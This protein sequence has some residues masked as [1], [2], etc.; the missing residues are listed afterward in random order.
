MMFCVR[1]PVL[2]EK[3]CEMRPS[4]SVRNIH[5]T[6]IGV[7]ESSWYILSDCCMNHACI[8]LQTYKESIKETDTKALSKTKNRSTTQKKL[9][10][11]E[12]SSKS[13]YHA[14]SSRVLAAE[15]R[16]IAAMVHKMMRRMT[17]TMMSGLRDFSMEEARAFG[18]RAPC[19]TFVSIPVFTT[20]PRTYSVLRKQQPRSSTLLMFTAI[21]SS[22]WIWREPVNFCVDALG[23][24]HSA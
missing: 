2:S 4:S 7:S 5:R 17:T 21:G 16:A 10:E 12:P 9:V 15:L 8:L 20:S 14:S 24:S 11:S 19:I 1:V 22:S 18:L 3:T 13:K 6:F 23:C